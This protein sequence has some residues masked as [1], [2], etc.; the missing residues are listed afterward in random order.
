MSDLLLVD[1]DRRIVELVAFFLEKRGHCVRRAESYR[2]ARTALIERAPELMLA[3]LELG[4]ERGDEEI[5]QLAREGL[6]PPTLVVSGYLDL[7]TERSLCA[8][9][10]VVGTLRKPF[11]LSGLEASIGTALAEAARRSDSSASRSSEHS[12][13]R[14]RADL[15]GA[16]WIDVAPFEARS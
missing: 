10:R 9:P 7:E 1:N 12:G 3:D 2:A 14:S 4:A 16:G 11:D 6:L 8:L 15:D 13:P 5:P